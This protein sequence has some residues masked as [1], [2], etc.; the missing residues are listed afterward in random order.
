[1]PMSGESCFLYA[2]FV[3][4]FQEIS[5]GHVIGCWSSEVVERMGGDPHIEELLTTQIL[6]HESLRKDY[7]R[8]VGAYG[9]VFSHSAICGSR[10]ARADAIVLS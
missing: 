8:Q 6:C 7:R 4:F 10:R 1:M 3:S 2:V 5:F 9:Y